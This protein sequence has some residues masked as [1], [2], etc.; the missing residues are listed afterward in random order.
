MAEM[1]WH[2][3][4]DLLRRFLRVEVSR[5]EGR[6][7]VR[8]LVAGCPR[9]TELSHRVTTELGLWQQGKPAWE[10]AY[11][12]VFQR[13]F[14]FATAEEQRVALEKLRGW[15]QWAML[16]PLN[17]QVRF[18]V[19]EADPTY[20]SFGLYD[21]LL[22]A[23]RL[24]MRR[25]PAEA[26][27]IVR[28]AILVAERLDPKRHGS[29]RVA[30]LRASAWAELGNVKRLASDFEGARR[31]FNEAWRILEEEGTND[32]L[33]QAHITS[34]EAS[35]IDELGDFETAEATLED[36]LHLY[37]QIGDVHLQG[38]T[39]IKMG[40]FIGKVDPARGIAHIQKAL[41][42]IEISREPRLE[43]CAQHDLAWLLNH[44]GQPEE[45]LAVLEKARPLYKAFPDSYTQ[46]RLHW[47]EGKIAHSLGALEDAESTFQQLWEELR[48]RDLNHELVLISIDLAE[49]L[50]KKGEAQRAAELIAQCYP[51][52]K[53]WGLHRY[54]LAAWMFFERALGE[55]QAGGAIFRRIREYYHRHWVRPATFGT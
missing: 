24:Y 32:P 31:A 40:E 53:G 27:D 4:E 2:I 18:A 39:L 3:P 12:E 25:E 52:L 9:C 23:S 44:G 50:V 36:A 42:L 19:V 48:A 21:R 37:Q 26:V 43:L 35:Y 16:E 28:L 45:A 11:E 55:A 46:F 10:H 51:I 38:R 41:P 6:G 1:E 17:P 30:D 7:V 49:T 22:E 14:A 47:L 8:H 20:H 29:E 33:E 34:L 5:E 54:A 15:G 13:A